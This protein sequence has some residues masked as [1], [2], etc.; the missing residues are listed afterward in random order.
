M[1]YINQIQYHPGGCWKDNPH[2]VN[3]SVVVEMK[4]KPPHVT[5]AYKYR[6]AKKSK[7]IYKT[8]RWCTE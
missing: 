5:I 1:A 8:V 2:N 3:G 7:Q 4:V 6:I